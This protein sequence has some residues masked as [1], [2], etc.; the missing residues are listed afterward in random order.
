MLTLWDIVQVSTKH[1]ESDQ[2]K[3]VKSAEDNMK[4]HVKGYV[5]K[6]HKLQL[7]YTRTQIEI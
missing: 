3:Y 4:G 2:D 7:K 1:L 6:M 5:S